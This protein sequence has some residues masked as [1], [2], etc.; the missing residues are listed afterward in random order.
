MNPEKRDTIDLNTVENPNISVSWDA[1][2]MDRMEG[3]IRGKNRNESQKNQTVYQ[4]D[5]R[6]KAV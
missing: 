6:G 3:S 5:N 4:N 1:E 2:S